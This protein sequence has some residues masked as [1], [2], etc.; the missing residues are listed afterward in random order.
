MGTGFMQDPLELSIII[1]N[2]NSAEFVRRCVRSVRE[3]TTGLDYEI[4]VVDNASFDGCEKMLKEHDPEVKYI[5]SD[6][7][8]GFA[9]ANNLAFE[10]SRGASLLFLNPDTEIVGPAVVRL[11]RALRQLPGVGAVGARLLNGDGTTQTSCIQ[12]FPTIMNQVL[13]S[14]Y[15]RKKWPGSPLWGVAAL[16][17]A[18]GNPEEAE[19]ISGACVMVRRDV[20]QRVG[21]FSEDYFM[22]TEDIDL[23]YKLR[24]AGCRNYYVPDATVIHFG[25]GSLREAASNFS[26]VMTRE[27]IW[28]FLRKTRGHVYGLGYRVSMLVSSFVRLAFLVTLFS[29]QPASRR[30]SSWNA[31]FRKWQAILRWSMNREELL[32]TIPGTGSL[33]AR[34][35]QN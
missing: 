25:G 1:V 10:A 3:Q 29:A 2:W 16:Q 18:H 35:K 30:R 27:S 32:K 5:Q 24:R 14:E 20:F 28:R 17:R 7:N 26:V 31:S 12:S 11:A 33:S 21:R 19:A 22:Y 23:C 6:Q 13:D 15:L 4:L 9:R 34:K 8:L